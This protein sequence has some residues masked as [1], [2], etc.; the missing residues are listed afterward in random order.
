LNVIVY[1]CNFGSYD[2]PRDDIRC[3]SSADFDLFQDQHRN[4]RFPKICPHLWLPSAP[5]VS[6]YVDA[7]IYPKIPPEGWLEPLG[8][9]DWAVF[10]HRDRDCIYEEAKECTRLNKDDPE[11]IN[12]QAAHYRSL[13]IPPHE[14][15]LAWCGILIR[16]HTQEV[17][18]LCEAW[19]AEYCRWSC[20]DQMSFPYIVG[21]F[22]K[23]LEMPR[24]WNNE[25]FRLVGHGRPVK[26]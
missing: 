8:D 11:T 6:V 7:N 12:A 5:D 14:G 25:Y 19:W 1:T 18:Q 3:F 20:R 9:A 24:S 10:N 23:R 2:K 13:G 15:L 22:A 17:K 21:T 26:A 16:R 4:S